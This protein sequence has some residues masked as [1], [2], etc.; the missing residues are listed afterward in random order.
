MN[1]SAQ[2]SMCRFHSNDI[3]IG[4]YKF[5]QTCTG[6][7]G[8]GRGGGGQGGHGPPIKPGQGAK[9]GQFFWP[10]LAY[11]LLTNIS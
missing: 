9:K 3:Q 4:T 5:L 6:S 2:V 10:Y 1:Q 7:R 11:P 8:V